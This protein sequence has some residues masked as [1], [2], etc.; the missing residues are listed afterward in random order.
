[1]RKIAAVIIG[2]LALA[3][4][5][6]KPVKEPSYIVQVSLGGWNSPD[7]SAQEI[8]GRLDTV[9]RI[10]PVKKVIIGWSLDKDIYS[11]VGE[12]LHGRNIRMLLWLQRLRHYPDL[13]GS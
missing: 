8:I 2:L 7:Y 12:Y 3:A 10:I 6:T 9:I 11:Q 13:T 5:G 4:C 1:M